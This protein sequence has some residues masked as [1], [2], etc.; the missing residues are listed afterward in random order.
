M[1]NTQSKSSRPSWQECALDRIKPRPG[2]PHA[3]APPPAD[4]NQWEHSVEAHKINTLTVHDIGLIV[5][6]ETQSFTNSDKA[7]DTLGAAREKLA[8][9][10]MNG[11]E[12]YG[13]GRP[14]T[15][16]PIEPLAKALKDM[17]T[18]AAYESSLRAAREAYLSATDPTRGAT[19]MKFLTNADRTSQKF[20]HNSSGRISLKTQSG[21]FNNS[22]LN[23][24]V[25]SGQV[26]I[27]TYG[28][29]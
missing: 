2:A 17:R 27:N 10:V 15:A 4:K 1:A 12:Q 24:D 19:H 26:Y 29:D 5:F 23:N 8:H 7:N 20:N 9:A 14:T 18:K 25:R 13:R 28:N 21:P 3:P 11:D 6:N 22:Y 16:H